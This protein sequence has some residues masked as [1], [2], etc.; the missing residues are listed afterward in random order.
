MRQIEMHFL[1]DVYV[2]CEQ[3]NGKRYNRA[4]LD[5]TY[6]SK[7]I[8][9]VLE[10]TVAEARALFAAHPAVERPLSLLSEVGLD[11]LPLG[12]PSPT[13]SGGE[14]Q[15]IKLA[16]EL[17]KRSTGK[18]LYVLDEPTTGLHFE[19]IRRLL[20]VL[21]KLVELGNTVLLIEH[22][23]DVI[24]CSDHVVDM[25]PEGGPAGGQLIAAGTPEEVAKV[26]K[27]YTGAYLRT[28]GS[29]S[30]WNGA[31]QLADTSVAVF[32][33]NDEAGIQRDPAQPA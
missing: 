11:Y 1:A 27:S 4:T 31:A 22:N 24:R 12:Q 8:A 25:G 2:K 23:L 19:D 3:C 9:D 17:S 6:K 33:A 20:D 15:R 29:P 30:S 5:V 28:T 7:N 10:L 32:A 26:K 14:A 16:R 21:Q 18:T 13:L